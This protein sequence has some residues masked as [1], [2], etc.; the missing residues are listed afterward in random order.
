MS[1]LL[2]RA[3]AAEL[4]ETCKNLP[5]DTR[6]CV[7]L[8][9]TDPPWHYTGSTG[10]DGLAKTHYNTMDRVEICKT[11]AALSDTFPSAMFLIWVTMPLSV[12]FGVDMAAHCPTLEYRTGAVWSKGAALTQ[13]GPTKAGGV[14]YYWRGVIEMLTLWRRVK[15]PALKHIKGAVNHWHTDEPRI[16]QMLYEHFV[17]VYEP[18]SRHSAK[19]VNAQAYWIEHLTPPG[20]V[21]CDPFA[22][23]GSV[24][25]ACHNTGRGFIGTEIDPVRHA[26]AVASL[27][28]LGVKVGT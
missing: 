18:K 4:I 21:V 17:N 26:N 7:S 13:D 6:N 23:F 22:G 20:S 19:P 5:S 11:L 8:V 27:N 15:A 14:G 3:A 24:A 10:S 25:A 16:S 2:Y 12:P 28:A 9:F 1:I